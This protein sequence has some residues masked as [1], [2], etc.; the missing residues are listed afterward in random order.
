[1]M[2]PSHDE[3]RECKCDCHK[4]GVTMFHCVPCCDHDGFALNKPPLFASGAW[5]R[6]YETPEQAD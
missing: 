1:M 5:K 4:P 2:D 3:I 6:S